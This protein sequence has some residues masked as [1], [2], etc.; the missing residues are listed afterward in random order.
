MSSKVNQWTLLV[1]AIPIAYSISLGAPAGLPLDDRQVEEL[2]LTSAQS[3]FA[4]ILIA[5]LRFS[6]KEAIALAVLFV[7]QLAFPNPVVR[8]WFIAFY[9]GASVGKLAWGGAAFRRVFF[10]L[11]FSLPGSDARDDGSALAGGTSG[12]S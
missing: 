12:P 9:L 2:L 10:G 11:L 7:G 5:D 4:A 8:W 1:G 6:R 3:L